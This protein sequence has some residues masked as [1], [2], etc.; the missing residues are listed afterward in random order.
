MNHQSSIDNR[1]SKIATPSPARQ[2]R[3]AVLTDEQLWGT[4]APAAVRSPSVCP[5]T[6][7]DCSAWES[8]GG[9]Q[10]TCCEFRFAAGAVA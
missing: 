8:L 3:T 9:C 2:N 4:D 6:G 1:Q 10:S 7:A 5:V